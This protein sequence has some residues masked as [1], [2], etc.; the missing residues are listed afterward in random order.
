ETSDNGVP[1]GA[2]AKGGKGAR[3]H[4]LPVPAARRHHS[5]KKP[6]KRRKRSGSSHNLKLPP[7]AT[8]PGG[9]PPRPAEFDVELVPTAPVRAPAAPVGAPAPA[10]RG[11][12]LTR[13]EW[14]LVG[15]GA[16]AVTFAVLVGMVL[17]WILRS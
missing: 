13:R 6:H 9:A 10:S 7:G 1:K 4:A 5:S 15:V 3:A 2:A 12:L 17:A 11:F 8:P 16:G 14:A